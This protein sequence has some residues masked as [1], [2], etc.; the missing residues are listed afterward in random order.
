M[1]IDKSNWIPMRLADVTV[2]KEENDKANASSRFNKFLKV[3]H[4]DAESLHIKRCGTIGEEE[5][6]PTFYKIFRKG[7]VLYPTR[8]PHLK[9]VALASFD[10][11]CGEKTLTL[12]PIHDLIDPR[13]YPFIFL[14]H[15]FF[16]HT[17]KSI[18]G[19]TNPHVRWR[20]VAEYDF[21][22][23]PKDQ[24]V[25]LAELLWAADDVSNKIETLFTNTYS[26]FS[27]YGSNLLKKKGLHKLLKSIIKT[28]KGR[29]PDILEIQN[30]SLLPYLSTDYLRN[31]GETMYVNTSNEN[32]IL[33]CDE[34]E[35]IIL[36]D[37]SN[38]GEIFKSKKGVVSSTMAIISINDKDYLKEFVYL[39]LIFNQY[40]IKK[41]NAG[42]AIPHVSLDALNS[43]KIPILTKNEQNA[44]IKELSSIL[45]SKEDINTHLNSST[46]I[47]KQ[48]INQIF[49]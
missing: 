29:K 46:K 39:M 15:S 8:N 6:P 22:L 7:Q 11:I 1:V 33:I 42:S 35:I 37:G 43:I 5:L 45:K 17:T 31:G 9:R 48:L 36:W 32:N 3:E 44:I 30:E 47:M 41:G 13:F 18:I 23:P 24:Q 19:S 49:S 12:E 28:K 10:G 20:D 4:M 34:G 40:N 21:L 26:L 38:A 2:K 27:S 25:K 14:A 16:S